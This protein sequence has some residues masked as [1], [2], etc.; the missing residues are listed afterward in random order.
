MAAFAEELVRQLLQTWDSDA[1]A[2]RLLEEARR[3]AEAEVKLLLKSAMKEDLLQRVA[4]S[5]D[6]RD[7]P[8]RENPTLSIADV[9]Q[10]T[11]LQP[12]V[13]PA[14]QDGSQ[15]WY[16]YGVTWADDDTPLNSLE[17]MDARFPLQRIPQGRLAAIAGRVVA[18]E[19][20]GAGLQE[21]A[22]DLAW[23]EARVRAHNAVLAG[24]GRAM[25]PFRF[26]AVFPDEAAVRRTLADR[27]QELTDALTAVD[28][29]ME[30]AVKVF[31]SPDVS[32]AQSSQE[33][34]AASQEPLTAGEGRSYLLQKQRERDAH[35]NARRRVMELAQRCC[36]SLA[37]L[38]DRTVAL[39]LQ[40][41][42]LS[43]LGDEMVL[44][45]GYL[46]AE[47]QRAPF[48]ELAATLA[49]PLQREGMRLEITGP[50]PPYNFVDRQ[51][52]LDA[53]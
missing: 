6:Q 14:S 30:W 15:A 27:Q 49:E 46:L 10:E 21:R 26:G 13:R 29:K 16:V 1:Q 32:A 39:S 20:S 50:W 3:E 8:S 43:S 52:T 35:R 28:G 48:R 9:E 42:D 51:P 38:A 4:A 45:V 17:G 40:K 19:F 18:D 31:R 24:A 25:V 36:Q 47:S 23:I 53:G 34:S 12:V 5:L 2:M 7:G 37:A 41:R 44:H 22:K 33:P 11:E